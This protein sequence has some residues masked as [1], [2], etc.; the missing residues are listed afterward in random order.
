MDAVLTDASF[1]QRR[2]WFI[3]RLE[4]G[5][6]AYHIPVVVRLRGAIEPNALERCI[7]EIVSRHESL[8]TTF[9]MDDGETLQ[10]IHPS[11]RIDLVEIQLA[12]GQQ[13]IKKIKTEIVRPFDLIKGPLMRSLLL[14]LAPEDQVLV[15]TMHHIVTDGWSMG[16]FVNEFSELYRAFA[17]AKSAQLPD[18]AIQY[19][20]YSDWQKEWLKNEELEKQLE[21]WRRNLNGQLP[22]LDL[23]TDKQRPTVRTFRGLT[24]S[25]QI[26]S[27]LLDGLKVLGQKNDKATL[28]MVLLA[29]FKTLLYRYTHQDDLLVGSPIANRNRSEIEGLIGFFVNTLVLRTSLSG[30]PSISELIGR[31]KQT[32]LGAYAHQDL[33]FESLVDSL[34]PERDRSRS[35]LFQVMFVLQNA[36]LQIPDFAGLSIETMDITTDTAKFDLMIIVEEHT[37]GLRVFWEYNTDLFSGS[38][39]QQMAGHYE[40]L[41]VA[42]CENDSQRIAQLPMLSNSERLYQIN[43]QNQSV[44]HYPSRDVIHTIVSAQANA[45]PNKT[46]LVCDGLRLTYAQLN[47][48]T[49]QLANH[50]IKLGVVVDELVGLYLNRSID[51]LVGV[52]G[53]LKAGGAYVSLDGSYPHDRLNYMIEDSGLQILLTEKNLR[54]NL[55][56]FPNLKFVVM[57]RNDDF[58]AKE[59]GQ[60]PKSDVSPENAAYVIYTS[61]STGKPKG[62]VVTHANVIRLMEATSEWYNFNERDVWTLFHSYSFDFSV[63]EMWG[64]LFYGGRLVIIPYHLSRSPEAF[65]EVLVDEGVTVLNQTPSAFRQLINVDASQDKPLSLRYIIFGGEALDLQIL[66]PWYER[67]GDEKPRLINMYGITETTVHVTYRPISFVDVHENRGS[68]IGERIPDLALYILDETMAP[69]PV[70]VT[71]ELFV[72]GPGLARGYLNRP[73]L[74]STRFI[75]NPFACGRLYRTGD[76]VRRLRDG[77][78]EYLGRIDNQVKIRGHRIELGEIESTLTLQPGI[79]QAVVS[80]RE[81]SPGEKRLVAYVIADHDDH[82]LTPADLR[83]LC[84]RHLPDYMVPVA[85]VFLDK[86]PLT[87]NGKINYPELPA[88]DLSK[89]TVQ[90]LFVAPTTSAE[91]VIAKVWSDVLDIPSPGIHDNFF[92]LGG[93][94]ILSLQIVAKTARAGYKITPKQ[95]FEFQTINDLARVAEK[96]ALS[97]NEIKATDFSLSGLE[98]AKLDQLLKDHPNVIDVYPLSPLQEGMLFQTLLEPEKGVYF[99]QITGRISGEIDITRFSNAWQIVLDRHNVLRTSFIWL[100][101]ENPLQIVF[102]SAR[103]PIVQLDWQQEST[104]EQERKLEIFLRRD[105]EKGF[106]LDNTPLMHITL[107]RLSLDS[108]QWIWSH[109]HVL[110]DGWSIPVVFQEVLQLYESRQT[111]DSSVLPKPRPYRDYIAWLQRQDKKEAERFWRETFRGLSVP[112]RL[113]LPELRDHEKKSG[114]NDTEVI[115]TKD[116]SLRLQE[117]CRNQQLTL[118]TLAQGAWA[119]LLSRYSNSEEIVFGI[120]V[121]GRPADI[122]GVDSMVGLF[123]NTLPLRVQV[124]SAASIDTWLQRIQSRQVEMRQYEYSRLVDIQEWSEIPKGEALF[125]TILVFEN[126]PI[127]SSLQ[128]RRENLHISHVRFVE[129]T[130]YPLTAAVIPGSELAVK[131]NFDG[132]KFTRSSV[133]RILAHWLRLMEVITTSQNRNL[134]QLTMDIGADVSKFDNWSQSRVDFGSPICSHHWFEE[135]V[136]RTPHSIAIAFDDK[137]LTYRELNRRANQLSNYLLKRG[138]YPDSP[139]AIYLEKSFEMIIALLGIIK[140]GGAYLPLDPKSTSDRIDFIIKDSGARLVISMENRLGFLKSHQCDAICLDRDWPK[141]NVEIDQDG[142]AAVSPQNLAYII[143]TSGSTGRPKGVMISH[144]NLFNLT[145]AQIRAFEIK[146]SQRIYQFASFSFD[147][148]VSEI[149]TSLLSGATLILGEN[150]D[151]LAPDQFKTTIGEENIEII[152]LPPA[153]LALFS[154]EDFPY[155]KTLVVAGESGPDELYH[156]W[157]QNHNLLNA[158]GPTEGTVCATIETIK[159]TNDIVTIGW[160]MANVSIYILDDDLRAVPVGVPGTIFLGGAGVARGYYHRCEWTAEKFVPEISRRIERRSN[161]QYWR[162]RSIS[163]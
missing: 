23:P 94:S 29:L 40:N 107:I 154:P 3:D 61:G 31:V 4:P 5:N 22:S 79:N 17:S 41:L 163:F 87:H 13:L 60:P 77:D 125:D 158:Y 26:S 101:V 136:Q 54:S 39:I 97:K 109:H 152:T 63:W 55:K 1:A 119:L 133:D 82:A 73:D 52:L 8:R 57:D 35:P 99:E 118:N 81:G 116:Q 112:A 15:I 30:N 90:R 32:C 45:H 74:T 110:L 53:V 21:Y 84:G 65:Y 51:M 162:R 80:V 66:K 129:Q 72:G 122:D 105:R 145:N 153:Y 64:A 18:L 92:E 24:E 38:T 123:I 161:V 28:F 27:K 160:P 127:D 139:V 148:S 33:P 9:A 36:P 93:D 59:S 126:Y 106:K 43:Q 117:W 157:C 124:N 128:E 149:F 144:A 2:L 104:S 47:T 91:K 69:I 102:E 6:P 113:K 86:Y 103:L 100:D 140:A 16:V 134:G 88:P 151:Q 68:V 14:V 96:K 150:A 95:L 10:I 121:S 46:A 50:L 7:N 108:W 85:F 48:R 11:M 49:N 155:L 89:A 44:S 147:A 146:R 159:T 137:T 76:L 130:N 98:Q 156:R 135:Q 120:T 20:D 114:F 111:P 70:G 58:L 67:H 71:G 143:Y 62:V 78:I 25:F 37:D 19:A 138:V 12:S 34:Q 142:A 132:Q 115:L 75:D 131:I 141:I 83:N 42:A 56:D